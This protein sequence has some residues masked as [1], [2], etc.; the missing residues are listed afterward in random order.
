MRI[1]DVEEEVIKNQK[2][3]EYCVCAVIHIA[4]IGVWQWN[5]KTCKQEYE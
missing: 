4:Q 5:I 2:V 1:K 3:E